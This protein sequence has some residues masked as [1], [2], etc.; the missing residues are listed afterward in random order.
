MRLEDA[1]ASRD[2]ALDLHQQTPLLQ[3]QDRH[4]QASWLCAAQLD[5]AVGGHE[6]FT[7][8]DPPFVLERPEARL[9]ERGPWG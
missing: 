3:M 5:K 2:D 4:E 9:H 1:G 6:A 7:V 8:A